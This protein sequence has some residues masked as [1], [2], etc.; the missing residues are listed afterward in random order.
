MVEGQL[1][2]QAVDAATT[3]DL[4]VLTTVLGDVKIKA[5]PLL[6]TLDAPALSVVR[7]VSFAVTDNAALPQCRV[8]AIVAGVL[9]GGFTGLVETTGNSPTCP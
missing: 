1:H 2:V 8:D 7:G 4:P 6:T 3:V 5:N 9:A